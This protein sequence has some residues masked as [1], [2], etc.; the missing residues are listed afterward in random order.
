M[1]GHCQ[2]ASAIHGQ[3][4]LTLHFRVVRFPVC[5]KP[6]LAWVSLMLDTLQNRVYPS[7]HAHGSL[8][9]R[10]FL[11]GPEDRQPARRAGGLVPAPAP[12]GDAVFREPREAT[13]MPRVASKNCRARFLPDNYD[14]SA[15]C[16]SSLTSS[17]ARSPTPASISRH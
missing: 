2:A 5:E 9:P 6:R 11:Q 14:R 1:S 17:T 10:L 13:T 4:W 7:L 8:C 12:Q 3:Y 16:R 15:S